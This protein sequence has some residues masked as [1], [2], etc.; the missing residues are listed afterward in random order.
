MVRYPNSMKL[1]LTREKHL[2]N[3][4]LV[5]VREPG[6]GHYGAL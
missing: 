6:G 3:W 1:D 4:Q 5:A 2:L